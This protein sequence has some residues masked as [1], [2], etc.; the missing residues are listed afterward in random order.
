MRATIWSRSHPTDCIVWAAER[1]HDDAE[2]KSSD[3]E[4]EK[5]CRTLSTHESSKRRLH[6]YTKRNEILISKGVSPETAE[7]LPRDELRPVP[8]PLR[9]ELLAPYHQSVVEANNKLR[10]AK[11]REAYDNVWCKHRERTARL[12]DLI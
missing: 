7:L 4:A 3:D 11:A 1:A 12:R 9:K 2:R 6:W 5:D 8:S 10:R